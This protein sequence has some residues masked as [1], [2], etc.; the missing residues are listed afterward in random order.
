M[1][2]TETTSV[3][4]LLTPGCHVDIVSTFGEEAV[5][6]VTRTIAQ[7][8]TIVAVGQRLSNIHAEGEKDNGYRTVTLIATPRTAE[9]IQLASNTSRVRLVLRGV[10]DKGDVA[11]EGVSFV[12][13]KGGARVGD[14][15]GATPVAMTSPTTQPIPEFS[16]SMLHHSVEMIRGNAVSTVDFQFTAPSPNTMTDT[17][18][19]APAVPQ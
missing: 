12:E 14:D 17:N 1:D 8:L 9:L 15:S 18:K 6:M 10:G 5:K 19:D 11:S 13:L 4:G 2:V 3:A 7:D 16:H